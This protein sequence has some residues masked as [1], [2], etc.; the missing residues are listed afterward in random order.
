MKTG[1]KQTRPHAVLPF[2]L[3]LF[4]QATGASQTFGIRTFNSNDGLPHNTVRAMV[5]DSTGF[6]WI[7]TWDGLARYNGY[8]FKNYFH[9]P[10]DSTSL[11]YFSV[12]DIEIDG[13]DNLWVMSDNGHLVRYDPVQDNFETPYPNA[14]PVGKLGASIDIDRNGDLWI[15][16]PGKLIKREHKS[17]QTTEYKIG[18][19]AKGFNEI[20]NSSVYVVNENEIWLASDKLCRLK[21]AAGLPGGEII[22]NIVEKYLVGSDLPTYYIDY[23][24]RYWSE[25]YISP[26]GNKWVFSN[27]GLFR[28]SENGHLTEYKGRPPDG[29]FTG[30]TLFVWQSKETGIN[31]LNPS[32]GLEMNL[33]RER[34]PASLSYYYQNRNLLWFSYRALSGNS[35]G[36]ARVI[37]SPKLFTNYGIG[38]GIQPDEPVYAIYKDQENTIW[39]GIR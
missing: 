23:P 4:L 22:L 12:R 3:L 24:E 30:D 28:L 5:S 27:L 15:I 10:G 32:T 18:N 36:L 38:S 17:G 31:L 6:L 37:I 2:I 29:E 33:P 7:A 34:L 14:F 35:L 16:G 13:S 39:T 26:G 19:T 21:K 1:N 11:P 9:I 8:E 20:D 25:F